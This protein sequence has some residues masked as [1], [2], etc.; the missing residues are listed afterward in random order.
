MEQKQVAVLYTN[1]KGE[2]AW[3]QIEPIEIWFGHTQWHPEDQW[4]LKALDSEKGAQRDFAMKDIQQW[5]DS[6]FKR[7]RK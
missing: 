3:R 1:W 6:E 2:T 5:S 4:L 7:H